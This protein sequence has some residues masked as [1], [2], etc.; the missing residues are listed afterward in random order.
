MTGDAPRLPVTVLTGFLGSGKTTLLRRL[1]SAPDMEKTAVLINELGEIGLDHLLV[2]AV[3]EGAVLLQ[4]GCLCCS[5]RGDLQRGLRD[6]LDGRSA[7][8]LPD[9]DRVVIETTG[10]ADP[11]PI[12]HTLIAD[13][14]LRH[15]VRLSNVVATVDGVHGSAQLDTHG[16][17]LRQAAMADRIVITKSDIAAPGAIDRLRR[18]LGQVNAA[19]ALID[20]QSDLLRP[21]E[22][23]SE[24]IADPATRLAEVRRW[25]AS[26]AADGDPHD[27]DAAPRHADVRTFSLRIEEPVDWTAFGVWLTSLLYCHGR[28]VLRVK[29]LLNV[30]DLPE[31]PVVLHGVQTVIH[32][33]THLDAWPDD[34]RASRLVFIVEGLD[35]AAIRRS[36]ATFLGAA[37]RL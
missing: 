37:A 26:P 35:P 36:M 20:A 4:N 24:G 10:L 34:D 32:P 11:T 22:L 13:P 6:L 23:L 5:L 18:R 19:A 2:R 12:V 27:H 3:H 7:A 31:R 30:A 15:Q 16:E 1:L 21:A 33:P 9:F 28:R 17:S 25:L 14:M 8:R 29:G